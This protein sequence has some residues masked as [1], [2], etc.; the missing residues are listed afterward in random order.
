MSVA[1][2]EDPVAGVVVP[3]T[4][5]RKRFELSRTRDTKAQMRECVAYL[6]NPEILV[7]E[8]CD[9][10]LTAEAFD[11]RTEDFC[12]YGQPDIPKRRWVD[13]IAQR[14][15]ELEHLRVADPDCSFRYIAREIVP[16]WNS[17]AS[18]DDGADR[19]ITGGGLD[20]VGAIEVEGEDMR[21][22]LGVVMPQED[23]SPYLSF[24]RLITCLAEVATGCQMERANRFL[25]KN[26]LPHRPTFDL[27][28]LVVD[29]DPDA[30]PHPLVQLTRDLAHQFNARLR[31]EW[32][33]PSLLRSIVHAGMR[34]S[35]DFD[36]SLEP[37]WT[38]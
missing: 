16:L 13:Q 12:A 33:F 10:F 19:R 5:L 34:D 1:K 8:F 37:L 28:M 9:S 14:L 35:D 27:H 25:F 17:V 30:Q 23:E 29:H 4:S 38:V 11:N 31:E 2:A 20:Y 32:Q 36:G 21:P 7:A 22:V 24:L 6:E 26:E 3:R 15:I 18:P